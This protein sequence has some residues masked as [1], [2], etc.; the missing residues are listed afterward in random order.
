VLVAARPLRLD[1]GGVRTKW[2]GGTTIER[3]ISTGSPATARAIYTGS[4]LLSLVRAQRSDM[5]KVEPHRVAGA[6][7]IPKRD[8]AMNTGQAAIVELWKEYPQKFVTSVEL[9]RESYFLTGAAPASGN[10]ALASS[11]M[12]GW[13]TLWGGFS[14]GTL[15]GTTNGLLEQAAESAQTA[16]VLN[17]DKSQVTF[18]YSQY[19]SIGS[20]TSEGRKKLRK[21]ILSRNFDAKKVSWLGADSPKKN[22]GVP[23]SGEES[24]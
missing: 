18:W 15:T 16:K 21:Q 5:T 9:C 19:E 12:Y 3:P 13:A 23:R 14:S 17:V 4:E 11:E 22:H 24:G 1:A 6:I 8:M 7:F 20:W 2:N 10:H